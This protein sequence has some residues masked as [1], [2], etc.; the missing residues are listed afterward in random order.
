[1][2]GI[3]FKAVGTLLSIEEK[4]SQSGNTY[5]RV[6]LGMDVKTPQTQFTK[7]ETFI[8]TGHT[9]TL[10]K[11]SVPTMVAQQ[12]PPHTIS[13]HGDISNKKKDDGTWEKQLWVKEISFTP[14]QPTVS[15]EDAAAFFNA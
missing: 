10:F 5:Y 11:S 1:M 9:A 6:Q 14:L 2:Q 15:P 7:K 8:L 12:L 13:F 4:T 3:F